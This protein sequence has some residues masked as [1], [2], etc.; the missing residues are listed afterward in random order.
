MIRLVVHRDVDA[1]GVD[2]EIGRG[3]V[4]CEG[5]ILSLHF[6]HSFLFYSHINNSVCQGN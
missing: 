2:L 6:C 4:S 3:G 5:I 1:A